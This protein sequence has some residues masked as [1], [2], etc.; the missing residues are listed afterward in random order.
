[1]QSGFT[2]IEKSPICIHEPLS[3]IHAEVIVFKC[4][5]RDCGDLRDKLR[6]ALSRLE[7]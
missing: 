3:V 2:Q 5:L 1:M 6:V 4:C 7:L